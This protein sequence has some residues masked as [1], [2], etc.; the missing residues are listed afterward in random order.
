MNLPVCSLLTV[1]NGSV[2][3]PGYKWLDPVAAFLPG[4]TTSETKD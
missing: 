2:P 4:I 1:R 3:A